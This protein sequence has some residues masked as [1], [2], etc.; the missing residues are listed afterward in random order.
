VKSV[1]SRVTS[2]STWFM[3]PAYGRP[4]S[5]FCC[6]LRIFAAATICIA[7][8]ICDVF[9]ID[10]IRRRMSRVLGMN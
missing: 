10:R 8:V 4:A 9:R 2:P 3:R 6:A 5:A 7:L 1:F